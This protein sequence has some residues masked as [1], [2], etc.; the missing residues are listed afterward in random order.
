[1]LV[2]DASQLFCLINELDM[3]SIK[4]EPGKCESKNLRMIVM[5][6]LILS[7]LVVVVTTAAILFVRS[8]TLRI[9]VYLCL[10]IEL[11]ISLAYLL[12]YL[13]N[14]FQFFQLSYLRNL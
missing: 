12:I 14:F 9:I 8:G 4:D 13:F 2:I 6:I 11:K 3:K 7:I 5:S 10:F 1:M